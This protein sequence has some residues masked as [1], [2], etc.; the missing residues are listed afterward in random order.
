MVSI[1]CPL[2][3]K[4]QY[5][6][7]TIQSVL[8]QTYQ[9]WEMIVVEN[10]STD[11]GTL[12]VERIEDSRVTLVRAPEHIRG[13]GAARNLGL[14]FTTG[15]WVLFLD[16][17]DLL[18]NNYLENL[19]SVGVE[20]D[21]TVIAG[22]WKAFDQEQQTEMVEKRPAGEFG[23]LLDSAIASSPWAVH[24]ALLN[25]DLARRIRWPED[26]DGLL[27][28]DNHFWFKICLHGTV[29][30]SKISGAL[31]RQN[32]QDC[33]TQSDDIAKWFD[34]V[35]A[36][37]V[38]NVEVLEQKTDRQPNETQSAN[39]MRLYSILYTKAKQE[40][41]SDYAAK[42]LAQAEFWLARTGSTNRRSMPM[43]ARRILGV[44][45]T[46]RLKSL[47]QGVGATG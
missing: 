18:E 14:E 23:G 7:E 8:D 32:T 16:A 30:Y 19:I 12:V 39:L 2:H 10:G 4:G 41:N 29:A 44:A 35:H 26:M 9:N 6:A 28:E 36:A 47:L 46:E 24:A 3:N 34:G 40:K 17:D 22:G 37:A 15:E 38:K 45:W 20:S 1:I 33:R 42:A 13:P 21:A 25:A 11:N 5:V 27:A 43:I 31:Y